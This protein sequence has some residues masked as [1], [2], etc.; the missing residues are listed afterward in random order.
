[1]TSADVRDLE[2]L[3]VLHRAILD[4]AQKLTNEG[5]SFRSSTA[6][7]MAHV[8]EVAPAYWREQLRIA[9]RELASADHRYRTKRV[10]TRPGDAATATEEKKQLLRWKARARLA[11]EKCQLCRAARREIEQAADRF[12]GPITH[13]TQMG[14][15]TLP[16]AGRR[17]AR[18]IEQLEDYQNS[19]NPVPS[20]D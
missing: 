15:S 2:S 19:A 4:L 8:T 18:L 1:M 7:A 16:A 3:R 12:L 5:Q 9:E 13:L 10:T 20:E 6:S 11:Q 14:T 17:L